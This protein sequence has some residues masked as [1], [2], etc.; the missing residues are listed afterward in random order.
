MIRIAFDLELHLWSLN[1]ISL[2]NLPTQTRGFWVLN[3][4]REPKKQHR[5]KLGN[6]TSHPPSIQIKIQIGKP[7]QPHIQPH[8]P[9]AHPYGFSL[10][11]VSGDELDFYAKLSAV[12]GS[13]G[14]GSAWARFAA[15]AMRCPGMARLECVK[16]SQAPECGGV[17]FGLF[18]S[19]GC[20]RIVLCFFLL[21]L[22][23][24]WNQVVCFWGVSRESGNW[25][26]GLVA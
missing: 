14:S 19:E 24:F 22:I 16:P 2:P 7:H 26:F 23:C 3:F 25:W 10:D 6:T 11:W 9:E 21:L 12:S 18:G 1:G 4:S 17:P 5:S 13:G 15:Q 20:G 8:H